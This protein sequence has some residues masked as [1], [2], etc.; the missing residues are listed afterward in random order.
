MDVKI[1][2]KAKK[3]T[4]K[5]TKNHTENIAKTRKSLLFNG[6]ILVVYIAVMAYQVWA[7]TNNKFDGM[8]RFFAPFI[9]VIAIFALFCIIANYQKLKIYKKLSSNGT[10]EKK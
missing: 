5:E 10:L 8:D 3:S 7:Y 2:K 4:P 6:L 1:K 9:W